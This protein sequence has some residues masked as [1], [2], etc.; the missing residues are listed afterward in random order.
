MMD[1]FTVL[2]AIVTILIGFTYDQKWIVFLILILMLFS[3]KNLGMML[4]LVGAVV[5]MFVLQTTEIG[6]LWPLVIIG[7][8]VLAFLIGSKAQPEQPEYYAPEMGYGGGY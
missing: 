3:S 1:L 5:A 6:V 2:A 4:L 8:I 7:L